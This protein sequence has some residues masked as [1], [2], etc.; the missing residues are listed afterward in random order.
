[1][2]LVLILCEFGEDLWI[3]VFAADSLLLVELLNI[4]FDMQMKP[5]GV[6]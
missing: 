2:V 4:Q 5:L 6:L 1:L 3:K